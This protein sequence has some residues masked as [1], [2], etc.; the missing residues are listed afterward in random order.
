MPLVLNQHWLRLFHATNER[1]DMRD[2]LMPELRKRRHAAATIAYL[3]PHAVF[4]QVGHGPPGQSWPDDALQIR[5]VAG[6]AAILFE[7]LAASSGVTTPGH[8]RR[9]QTDR[10]G[11]SRPCAGL[12][13]LAA[14]RKH[15]GKSRSSN[16]TT[17]PRAEQ[18]R[19]GAGPRVQRS[20]SQD[21]Q[22]RAVHDEQASR[23]A[24]CVERRG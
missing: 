20:S 18:T 6:D 9:F 16:S 5:A 1:N 11:L 19:L 22:A 4:R 2:L 8:G 7:K 14:C 23:E 13:G 21:Q 24:R 12:N 15:D 3:R 17:Q 10:H